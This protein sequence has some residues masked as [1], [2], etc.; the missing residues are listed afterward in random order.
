MPLTCS[1]IY[2][3]VVCNTSEELSDHLVDHAREAQPILVR[4]IPEDLRG[5]EGD[6]DSL[7]FGMGHGTNG[8]TQ[9]S[10]FVA[11]PPLQPPMAS[12]SSSLANALS[13]AAR[14]STPR[15]ISSLNRLTPSPDGYSSLPNPEMPTL[16]TMVRNAVAPRTETPPRLGTG[17]HMYIQSSQDSDS[18]E[19]E[20]QLTQDLSMDIS[21]DGQPPDIYAGELDWAASSS[22]SQSSQSQSQ[23]QSQ[24]GSGSDPRFLR[25][26]PSPSQSRQ[27]H[28]WFNSPSRAGS[29]T[30]RLA[31]PTTPTRSFMSGSIRMRAPPLPAPPGTLNP[32]A[33]SPSFAASEPSVSDSQHSFVP[34]SQAPYDS[35]S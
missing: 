26:T 34:R 5:R 4:E 30:S 1:W 2:C 19:V 7:S 20:R 12:S 27:Q 14:I 28:S 35:Q 18:S 11:R 15:P 21:F 16:E 31:A 9:E 24:S 3:R 22:R 25:P 13:P 6:G 17:M 8:G 10:L 29:N 33:L 23:S 32:I